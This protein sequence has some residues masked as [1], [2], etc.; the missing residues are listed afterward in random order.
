MDYYYVA[1]HGLW[2]RPIDRASWQEVRRP[3]SGSTALP[4]LAMAERNGTLCA[5][6]EDGVYHADADPRRRVGGGPAA[7]PGR[8]CGYS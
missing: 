7:S 6:T 1:A 8:Y 5:G 4:V 2:S 3:Q